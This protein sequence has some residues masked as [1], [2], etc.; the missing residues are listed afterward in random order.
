MY[1]DKLNLIIQN[2]FSNTKVL[3]IT[4]MNSG[5]INK[6]YIVEHFY[7]GKKSKFVLQNLSNIFESREA[8]NI[9]H[10][11]ITDHINTKIND[12]SF[13][14]DS[15]RWEVPNL[16]K[17]K[18]NNSY[19]LPF[20][21][22]FW[23]AMD[24]I[25]KTI[26]LDYLVDE[27]MAFQ[28]GLGLAKFHL[29]C[30]DLNYSI[31]NT[32]I[33]N[34]HDTRFYIDKYILNLMNYDFMKYENK[35]KTRI[36]DLINSLSN[37]IRFVNNLLL[38]LKKIGIS[39]NV[40]HGDPKLSNFLFDTKYKYVVSLIDLDT[41]SSGYLLT[42]LADCI[43]SICNL[44]RKNSETKNLTSFDTKSCK[45][46]L[47]GYFS[48][49]NK[50]ETFRFIPEF[51]YLIIFELT[52]RYLTDFLQSNIYFNIE[53]ETHNLFRAETQYELLLSFLSQVPSLVDELSR[54]GIYSNATL[55]S[56][57]QKFV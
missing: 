29:I 2:F 16:I 26:S 14:S 45:Y 51:I 12:K 30:S 6:T 3:D 50:N 1:F 33:R 46:F 9:N 41:V 15:K 44:G 52:I 42:D 47:E 40:I 32:N 24:Y 19:G 23:R 17:C 36:K 21:S 57:V 53:Y 43:R 55:F 27:S 5:L 34:F 38:D 49:Y 11:L 13:Y 4:M 35:V 20:E 28:T 56:N 18:S 31:L 39:Q 10:K 25:D 37:H 48:I 7:N 22:G 54:I 8:V